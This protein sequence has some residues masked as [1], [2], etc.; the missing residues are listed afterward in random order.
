MTKI[1][2][3]GLM[4]LKDIHAVNQAHPDLAGFIFAGGRHHLELE[5]ALKMRQALDPTIKSVGVFVNASLEEM[6]QV[7]ESG[8]VSM[9]QLHGQEPESIVKKLQQE[10]IPVIN[11]FKPKDLNLSTSANYIMID[12]GSGDGKL[13]DWKQFKITTDKPLFIAGALNQDNLANAIN[14]THPDLVDLS[15]GVE[16]NGQKDPTKIQQIVTKAHSLH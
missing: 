8:A 5:Q 16:T 6:L 15:R 12:S 14:A 10:N 9:I 11:V 4:T 2:I 13:I 1:K 7:V 3:C